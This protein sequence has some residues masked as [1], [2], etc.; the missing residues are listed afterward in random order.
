MLISMHIHL[1]LYSSSCFSSSVPLYTRT[2][3]RTRTRSLFI[4]LSYRHWH[5]KAA[6]TMTQVLVWFSV[7]GTVSFLSNLFSCCGS[8]GNMAVYKPEGIVA[9]RRWRAQCMKI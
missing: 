5:C 6:M 7:Q 1:K 9:D 8:M 4:L 2:R 3:T